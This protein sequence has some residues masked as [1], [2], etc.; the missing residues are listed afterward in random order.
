MGERAFLGEFEQMV[1][2]AVLQS[3]DVAFGPAISAELEV[4]AGRQV[5]R[6]ALYA[7]L[8]RLEKKG[9]LHWEIEAASSRSRGNRRRRFSVTEKGREELLDARRAFDNLWAGLDDLAGRTVG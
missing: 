3:G 2:L 9:L 6:G 4:R 1:L 5:S 7:T 8:D